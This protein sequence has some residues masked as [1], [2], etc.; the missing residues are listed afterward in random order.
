MRVCIKRLM[1][2]HRVVADPVSI[3]LTPPVPHPIIVEGFASTPDVDSDR[4]KIRPHALTF[5]PW[6]LPPLLWK[7]DPAQ[8]AGT[9][10]E[11]QYDDR[12]NLTIRATVDHPEAR[13]AGAFSIGAKV[14]DYVILNG[15]TPNF[16]AVIKLAELSE[17]SL[18]DCP[19]NTRAVVRHRYRT[20]AASAFYAILGEKMR[21]LTELTEL[22]RQEQ[23]YARP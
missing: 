1:R 3:P 7:H 14:L 13:R 15:D 18:T 10:D 17:I 12:G 5:L 9:I 22:M 2:E 4:T 20:S 8:V 11:L 19:A 16:S 21:R 6:R 23:T